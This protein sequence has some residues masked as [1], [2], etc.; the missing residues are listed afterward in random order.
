[1]AASGMYGSNPDQ[2]KTLAKSTTRGS[3]ELIQLQRII[4][5]KLEECQW[6]GP[7]AVKFRTLWNTDIAPKL[8]GAAESMSSVSKHLRRSADD[9]E[10]VSAASTVSGGSGSGSS[11]PGGTGSGSSGSGGSP[12]GGGAAPA[13]SPSDGGAVFSSSTIGGFPVVDNLLLTTE[14]G[15]RPV[16]DNLLLTSPI[17]GLPVADN[18]NLTAQLGGF[19]VADNLNLT[20]PLVPGEL[21][22]E[23]SQIRPIVYDAM[24]LIV[25]EPTPLVVNEPM[26]LF[27]PIGHDTMPIERDLQ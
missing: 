8:H 4:S 17:G 22:P 19:P 15:G 5:R 24:P 13:G 6:H 2:L 25:D 21:G 26:P 18:L 16:A 20:A 3:T 1:M 9:Q 27:Q 12:S 11:T 14:L 7:D 10:S 23:S